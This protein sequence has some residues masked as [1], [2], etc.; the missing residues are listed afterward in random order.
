M[1]NIDHTEEFDSSVALLV[2]IFKLKNKALVES[3]RKTFIALFGSDCTTDMMT[4]AV[5]QLAATDSDTCHWALH[6]FY[7]LDACLK[8]IEGAI[9]FAIQKLIGLGF[10]L[11]KDFSANANGEI[12]LNRAA[13][14][15]LLKNISDADWNFL[16]E[17]LQVVE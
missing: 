12:L 8:L 15:T 9:K 16:K 3:C 5:F 6:T 11:G 17:I 2:D 4:A 13:K 14:I 10:V 1:Y 7:E